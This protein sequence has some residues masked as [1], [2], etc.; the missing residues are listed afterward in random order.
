MAVLDEMVPSVELLR[1]LTDLDPTVLDDEQRVSA[2]AGWERMISFC[3]AAQNDV[4]CRRH[5]RLKHEAGWSHERDPDDHSSIWTDPHGQ[6]HRK[7]AATLPN[8][9]TT[10]AIH[11]SDPDRPRGHVPRKSRS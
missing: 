6:Q 2:A 10:S 5:H 1:A 7:P 8:P 11:P 4:L 9:W 3:T